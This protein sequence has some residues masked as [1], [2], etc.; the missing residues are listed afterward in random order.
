MMYGKW[1]LAGLLALNLGL[2]AV[3]YL[4]SSDS[5]SKAYAQAGRGRTDFITVSG[6]QN[7]KSVLYIFEATSGR[8]ACLEIDPNAKTIKGVASANVASDFARAF[9]EK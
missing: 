8:L 5:G 1:L 7:N 3:L 6:H 9:G 2:G 4:H